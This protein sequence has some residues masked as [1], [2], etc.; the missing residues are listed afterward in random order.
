MTADVVST[1]GILATHS[2]LCAIQ[3]ASPA[4]ATL[5]LQLAYVASSYLH[6]LLFSLIFPFLVDIHV[7]AVSSYLIV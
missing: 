6:I 4:E 2:Y 3:C 1:G 7:L 5:A